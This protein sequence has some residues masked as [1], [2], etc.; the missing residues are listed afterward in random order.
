M[1][2]MRAISLRG[3]GL[4]A[5][6][7]ALALTGCG[8]AEQ[9]SGAAANTPA[10]AKNVNLADFPKADGKKTLQ[11]LQREVDA[12]QD[13]NLLP[14]ANDFVAER[15][16][17]LPFGLFDADRHPVWGPTVMYLATS[18]DSPALGPFPAQAHTFTVPARFQSETSKADINS[19]GNGF[20]TTTI[21]PVKGTKKIGVL[22]LTK[23]GGGF[24]AAAVPVTLA[25][26]D[27]AVAPGEKAP[28]IK[29]PTGTTEAELDAIDTRDPHDDMHE[30][31]LDKALE[32]KKPIVLVFATPKLCASRVCAPVVDV[33]ET[34]HHTTGADV[35]FIHNEI[36][37]DNDLNKG[38]RKQVREFGLTSEPFTFVIGAD[39]KVV[40]QL[41]GPY[42]AAELRAA[43][44][45]AEKK[46]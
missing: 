12:K 31:S 39:G 1:S 20:Y 28:A 22:T 45:K 27:P 11:D 38:F 16:N 10:A 8:D 30:I 23:S 26:R 18:S 35:I 3:F 13:A 2:R 19:I 40:E 44:A 14:A 41:Q 6:A 17:R 15:P 25:S 21:P 9:H 42:D 33:A 24:E 36:Y 5:I 32:Q 46:R 37:N 43:I 34:V 29:T 4:L 7:A